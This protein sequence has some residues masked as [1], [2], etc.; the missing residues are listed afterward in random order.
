MHPQPTDI[1]DLFSPLLNP[2]SWALAPGPSEQY[3]SS[4]RL[5]SLK[6]AREEEDE[7]EEYRIE[8]QEPVKSY[9]PPLET[10]FVPPR[11]VR[12]ATQR[13]ETKAKV[14]RV[15]DP[16]HHH[17]PNFNLDH[18]PMQSFAIPHIPAHVEK[19]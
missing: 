15:S 16:L 9:L 6:R 5:P 17:Q 3:T 1:P 7:E 12:I 14:V 11:K 10:L 2:P 4:N 13:R 19:N 18:Q 8:N